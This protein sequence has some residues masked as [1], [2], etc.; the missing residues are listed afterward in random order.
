MGLDT[1]HC[2]SVHEKISIKHKKGKGW[3]VWLHQILE[4]LH[5]LYVQNISS[6]IPSGSNPTSL[7]FQ[8]WD[9]WSWIS[10]ISKVTIVLLSSADL[11]F[12]ISWG[13][14]EVGFLFLMEFPD[15]C[16]CGTCDIYCVTLSNLI[17]CSFAYIYCWIFK[18][19]TLT[20]FET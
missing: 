3:P 1:N 7:Q 9:G 8:T 16:Y 4:I 12:V 6:H 19:H 13:R 14:L 17:M 5:H 18:T 20:P 10:W 2:P 11:V 15:S